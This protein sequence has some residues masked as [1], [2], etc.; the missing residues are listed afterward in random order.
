MKL[1]THLRASPPQ[2]SPLLYEEG[3]SG[4]KA[5]GPKGTPVSEAP[6]SPTKNSPIREVLGS[7]VPRSRTKDGAVKDL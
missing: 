5:L 2:E 3:E 6:P 4:R 1:T 7:G